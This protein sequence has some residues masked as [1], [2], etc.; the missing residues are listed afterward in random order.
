[1]VLVAAIA[2]AAVLG[3]QDGNEQNQP[4]VQT[5]MA[6]TQ[7]AGTQPDA[8]R[9]GWRGRGD[10]F[11]ARLD[12]ALRL[13]VDVFD[14]SIHSMQPALWDG[15][16]GVYLPDQPCKLPLVAGH[17]VHFLHD[18][19]LY[20]YH[21]GFE[22]IAA[23]DW[24]KGVTLDDGDPAEFN[25]RYS[26]EVSTEWSDFDRLLRYARA[27]LAHRVGVEAEDVRVRHIVKVLFDDGCL[28]F[29]HV[30]SRS[31]VAGPVRGA[32]VVLDAK[33]D[34]Y[35]YHVSL[36][37]IVA[38]DFEAGKTTIEIPDEVVDLQNRMRQ[39]LADRVSADPAEVDILSFRPVAWH[40]VC[41]GVRWSLEPCG[42]DPVDGYL[43]DFEA[44][45]HRW[46]YHSSETEFV[47]GS[48]TDES[49]I[50]YAPL[51]FRDVSSISC[52]PPDSPPTKSP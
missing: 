8:S 41:L 6:T 1:M 3:W 25:R 22:A 45:G 51:A 36:Q 13:G 5:A 19:L 30:N 46:Q 16:I 31:C 11:A 32:I 48:P 18:D 29:E 17:V 44:G 4:G 9:D 23:I 38:T 28:G 40:D 35:Q 27:E 10:L 37:G 50:V 15:C 12:L 39:H 7:F 24:A 21:V 52:L 26:Q 42:P 20:R 14:V 43:A 47:A 49:A 2:V 34:E 33:G